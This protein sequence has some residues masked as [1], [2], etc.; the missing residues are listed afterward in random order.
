MSP[1]T[2]LA[3]LISLWSSFTAERGSSKIFGGE[4]VEECSWP[5]VVA[6]GDACSGT[7]I[8]P[9][10]VVY[11][12]HCGVEVSS[13]IFGEGIDTGYS[14]DVEYCEAYPIGDR[15]Q[16]M[17]FA[18]C[19]LSTPQFDVAIIPPLLGCEFDTLMPGAS[20]V[21]VGF[22]LT[23]DGQSGLKRAT[24]AEFRRTTDEGEALVGGEGHDTCVGDSGGPAFVRVRNG[25][26]GEPEFRQL[27]VASYGGACGSG[28]FF[29]LMR[30][31]VPWLE[32]RSQVDISPCH[33][34][35]GE[36]SPSP[37][38]TRFPKNPSI[39]KGSWEAG[40]EA[41]PGGPS[42][43]CGAPFEFSADTSG[44]FVEWQSPV[45]FDVPV[46]GA[47]IVLRADVD[48]RGGVGVADVLF[49]L[50]N[51]SI[52]GS[53]DTTTG[54]VTEVLLT[55][56]KYEMSVFAVDHEGNRARPLKV[57]LDVFVARQPGNQ[58]GCIVGS[59]SSPLVPPV[60]LL[61]L[62][63]GGLVVRRQQKRDLAAGPG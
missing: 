27:G 28:G 45:E 11:A 60:L 59:R 35:S 18:Y 48:D 1:A 51:A 29:S 62:V 13:V 39:G 41:E 4:D 8:H 37:M 12:A 23:E 14:V 7:L 25:D 42:Q 10:V 43:S 20:T 30:N 9:S 15:P 5:S 34:S 57:Q 50:D 61:S 52:A 63:F 6:V 44:P 54:W 21:L 49:V 16:G 17:D 22:G 33:T 26:T 24:G 3:G 19:L 2:I 56:G 40:C 53:R 38:C 58:G 47:S 46:D 32:E 55:P 31:G 36:W